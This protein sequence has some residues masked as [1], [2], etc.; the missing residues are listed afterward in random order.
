M[1]VGR[2][3]L[4]ADAFDQIRCRLWNLPGLFVGLVNRSDRIGPDNF[5]VGIFFLQVSPS[6]GNRAAG[7]DAGYKVCD[8]PVGLLPEFRAGRAIVRFRISRM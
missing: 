1:G 2:Q 3:D 8:L 6:A 4:L 7:A 5:Y